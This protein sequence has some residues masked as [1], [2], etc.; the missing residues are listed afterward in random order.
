MSDGSDKILL[1]L[2]LG[3]LGLGGGSL[4]RR[5]LVTCTHHAEERTLHGLELALL[6]LLDQTRTSVTASLLNLPKELLPVFVIVLL[7]LLVGA[8]G[9][10]ALD[11]EVGHGLLGAGLAATEQARSP[12]AALVGVRPLPLGNRG[13]LLLSLLLGVLAGDVL[14]GVVLEDRADVLG[15][16]DGDR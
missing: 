6:V 14:A 7:L 3:L 15:S 13:L 8:L 2:L 4:L 16:E 1:L 11:L 10:L 9:L 12:A 5:L